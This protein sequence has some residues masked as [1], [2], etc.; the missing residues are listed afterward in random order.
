MTSLKLTMDSDSENEE[1]SMTETWKHLIALS[2]CFQKKVSRRDSEGFK[3][4]YEYFNQLSKKDNIQA[5]TITTNYKPIVNKH[6]DTQYK[7]FTRHLKT[8]FNR[9][10]P[11]KYLIYF[12]LNKSGVI[13]AHGITTDNAKNEMN[14]LSFIGRRNSQEISHQTV[15]DIQQYFDYIIKDQYQP[16]TTNFKEMTNIFNKELIQLK[17]K[18][19][20]DYQ[21]EPNPV[22]IDEISYM[23][24]PSC[25][26]YKYQMITEE[27]FPLNPPELKRQ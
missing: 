23:M 24:L 15:K 26:R 8:V 11:Y 22:H 4:L 10:L 3:K 12:E 9:N 21:P 6:Y 13:H 19:Y 7:M 14:Q 2:K 1:T 18:E 5:I 25:E 17:E 20:D 27:D 16:E